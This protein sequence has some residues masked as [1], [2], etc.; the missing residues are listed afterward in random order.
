MTGRARVLARRWPALVLTATWDPGRA[1]CQSAGCISSPSIRLGSRIS[2][3][4]EPPPPGSAAA[5]RRSSS[6]FGRRSSE[7]EVLPVLELETDRI[8]RDFR[9][10]PWVDD[11]TRVEYPAAGHQGPSCL[12][13]P[14]RVIPIRPRRAG[15]S[16]T[17]TAHILPREDID[18]EKLG[19]LIRI[20]GTGL[21]PSAENR[22]GKTWK[23][24][25]AGRR[26]VARL[27][28]CVRGSGQA[29]RVPARAGPS[30]RGCRRPGTPRSWRSSRPIDRP[31]LVRP[32]CRGRHDPLGRSARM[33]KPAGTSRLRK[34]GR[35]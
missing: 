32:E 8:E 15:R 19:P 20:V 28:R 18:T 26:G 7:A 11:V 24:S 2:S 27:E 9:L 5:P 22:P 4:H 35:S 23:S 1:G 34:N 30:Q 16:S 25:R 29:R 3:S 33:R 14:G 17:V 10:F 21:D 31:R 6:R 12:Q 13:E